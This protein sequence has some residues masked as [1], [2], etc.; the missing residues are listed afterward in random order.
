[1]AT[2]NEQEKY[3]SEE[4]CDVEAS[5]ALTEQIYEDVSSSRLQ[6]ESA[7]MA[8]V[9]G[10]IDYE[11]DWIVDSRCS[12]HMTGDKEKLQ[13]ITEYKWTPQRVDLLDSKEIED[14]LQEETVEVQH[15]PEKIKN[16]QESSDGEELTRA[17]Q[18][19]W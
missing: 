5:L 1:M 9:P 4:E 16:S 10:W 17:T 14:M 13:N 6:E 8:V 15:S 11:N 18:D 7:L 2:S 19:P 3:N 12:N